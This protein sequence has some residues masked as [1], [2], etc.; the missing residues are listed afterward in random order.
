MAERIEVDPAALANAAGLTEELAAGVR[1]VLTTLQ[2]ELATYES[3]GADQP[4]G[5]DKMGKKFI[6]GDANNGY[7]A[8][9]DNL[10]QGLDG[11][12]GTL[13]EFAAGQ[14][15]AVTA[16]TSADQPTI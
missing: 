1:S 15:D 2:Q 11:M 12:A 13:D 8:S 10:L 4:W 6:Q 5:S 7:Q 9:R 14:R 3:A 16:L